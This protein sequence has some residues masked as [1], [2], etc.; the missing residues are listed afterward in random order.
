MS[1]QLDAWSTF[2]KKMSHYRTT[3]ELF[4]G[5]LSTYQL[6][7]A[8]NN[9]NIF[10]N[11]SIHSKINPLVS[12]LSQS[13]FTVGILTE[14]FRTKPKCTIIRKRSLPVIAT[15][16]LPKIHRLAN[17]QSVS[18]PPASITTIIPHAHNVSPPRNRKRLRG[19]HGRQG[20]TQS[21]L[22][23]IQVHAPSSSKQ[24]EKRNANN[25][26]EDDNI[27]KTNT[28]NNITTDTSVPLL[29]SGITT[30]C[31]IP[32]N[33]FPSIVIESFVDKMGLPVKGP[34][35]PLFGGIYLKS[36]SNTNSTLQ[37]VLL[38]LT[39]NT[40]CYVF[41]AAQIRS[42]G[43][44]SKDRKL[45]YVNQL[46]END[47]SMTI[48]GK[49]VNQLLPWSLKD[50][51]EIY[52]IAQEETPQNKYNHYFKQIYLDLDSINTYF[53]N[54]RTNNTMM[55]SSNDD[56]YL[57]RGDYDVVDIGGE[58]S[59]VQESASESQRKGG[60]NT[61]A[62][63]P[64]FINKDNTLFYQLIGLISD[65]VQKFVDEN[66]FDNEQPIMINDLIDQELTQPLRDLTGAKKS[67][68]QAFTMARQKLGTAE[69]ILN[70]TSNFQQ[71]MRHV[72]TH[73]DGRVGWRYTAVWTTHGKWQENI[74]RYTIILYNRRSWQDWYER[75]NK[76]LLLTQLIDDYKIEHNGGL[77][78]DNNNSFFLR[79]NMNTFKVA[80]TLDGN[81]NIKN[82]LVPK[83]DCLSEEYFRRQKHFKTTTFVNGKQK[84]KSYSFW[85]DFKWDKVQH[86]KWR[87]LLFWVEKDDKEKV[88]KTSFFEDIDVILLHAMANRFGFVSSYAS[89]INQLVDN[90]NLPRIQNIQLLD[91]ALTCTSQILFYTVVKK[92]EKY[93]TKELKGKNL[94][95]EFW[96]ICTKNDFCAGGGPHPR[97]QPQPAYKH[98]MVKE[99]KYTYTDGV[100]QSTLSESEINCILTK[101]TD[102]LQCAIQNLDDGKY[103]TP[104]ESGGWICNN[105]PDNLLMVDDISLLSFS[106]LSVFTGLATSI[107]AI[108]TAK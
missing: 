102:I 37:H 49:D 87:K 26:N 16:P 20:P 24:K 72:D 27:N 30:K 83:M 9:S 75:N 95:R 48:K 57:S 54:N 53:D 105:S 69:E 10:L 55:G 44:L 25:I 50:Q 13:N 59:G 38:V 91:A 86:L 43:V 22:A 51:S 41:K 58:R 3:L 98:V 99:C 100:I 62:A 42:H 18:Q 64:H 70:N 71:T 73:N 45:T 106:S 33:L 63:K 60:C 21:D 103:L 82:R 23:N 29:F 56:Y 14:I 74:Y 94:F 35:D 93:T 104:G 101:R 67:R 65:L 76:C 97:V 81:R 47:I 92:K 11:I 80:T 96:I 79:A 2:L 90:K 32:R 52:F 5:S 40:Y 39:A 4:M 88:N 1:V 89:A 31:V 12:S 68:F 107:E 19:F 15:T 46:N 78:Y 66:V 28:T 61:V 77:S 17:K 34:R 7:Q 8:N 36:S 108:S 84:T 6:K 85:F